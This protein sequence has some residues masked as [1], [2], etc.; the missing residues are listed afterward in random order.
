MNGV[1][2]SHLLWMKNGVLEWLMVKSLVVKVDWMGEGMKRVFWILVDCRGVEEEEAV[3]AS[4]LNLDFTVLFSPNMGFF[5]L[6][7]SL[8]IYKKPK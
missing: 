2:Y 4:L 8:F 6:L 3:V 5:F 1:E 7:N